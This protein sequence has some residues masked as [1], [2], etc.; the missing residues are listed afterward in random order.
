[1]SR[2]AGFRNLAAALSY[3]D[4]AWYAAGSVLANL[5]IWFHR[6]SLAWLAW[7]LTHSTG[8]LGAIAIAD[9]AASILVAPVAGAAADR[10]N[11]V[12]LS[13]LAQVLWTMLAAALALLVQT[14]L[15]T[16]AAVLAGA[17][18]A[19]GIATMMQPVR[20]A[21]TPTLVPRDL[22]ATAYATDSMC[23]HMARFLGPAAAGVIIAEGGIALSFGVNMLL[24]LAALGTLWPLL[25]L[26][27]SPAVGGRGMVADIA[28]AYGYAVRHPG[29]GPMLVT[30]FLTAAAGRAVLDLL[31]GYADHWY[32]AG[33]TGL[34]WMIGAG[35][36][37]ATFMSLWMTRGTPRR[38]ITRRIA[39]FTLLAGASVI[40]FALDG[41]FAAALACLVVLGIA[42]QASAV[43]SF[44]AVQFVI[45]DSRRGRVIGLMG[46]IWRGSPAVGAF[47]A[48]AAAEWV[49]L[50]LPPIACGAICLAVGLWMLR[51]LN[52]LEDA[53]EREAPVA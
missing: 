36:V 8:W 35:G 37:G 6:I 44:T 43:L 26:K 42:M 19:G 47:A 50:T 15:V 21:L 13:I 20:A 31:P 46:L 51:S 16:V 34:A 22:Q 12:H 1:M 5:G 4:F 7:D 45:D 53:L 33:A 9:L 2:E 41:G 10:W 48:G 23:F 24:A 11:R 38:G 29:L 25:H 32:E 28:E 14:G 52:R 40:G 3:P 30:G 39:G 17:A 49:G 27:Q 18:A